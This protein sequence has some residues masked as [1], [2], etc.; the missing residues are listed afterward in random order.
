MSAVNPNIRH[1][2]PPLRQAGDVVLVEDN[3]VDRRLIQLCF[4]QFFVAR[5]WR[6]FDAGRAA[7]DAC[8]SDPPDLMLLDLH[9]PDFHGL[10]VLRIL[11]QAA[12]HFAVIVLTSLPEDVLPQALLELNVIGY[13]DKYTLRNGLPSAVNSALDGRLFFSASRSSFIR[14]RTV[15]PTVSVLSEREQEI[16]RLVTHGFPSKQ[17]AN[18]LNLS[19]RTVENHRA[20]IM[21]RLELVNVADL[22]RWCV[23][24]GLD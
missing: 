18:R 21:T 16:A 20:R 17:I 2:L 13:L 23:R 6:D 15:R 8:L 19:V 1:P 9:L 7:L 4:Q 10:E 5:R 14:K 11:R 22:V 24:H 3:G 12:H